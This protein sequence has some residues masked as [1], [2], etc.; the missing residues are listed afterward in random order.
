MC[1]ANISKLTKMHHHFCMVEN[2]TIFGV[3]KNQFF[4]LATTQLRVP[5]VTWQAVKSVISRVVWRRGASKCG[6]RDRRMIGRR[7]ERALAGVSR[8]DTRSMSHVHQLHLKLDTPDMLLIT[9]LA[10]FKSSLASSLRAR[11]LSFREREKARP[12]DG[13]HRMG[14][15]PSNLCDKHTHRGVSYMHV[16]HQQQLPQILR[17]FTQS[18]N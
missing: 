13:S 12:G 1:S 2:K 18:E 9:L 17:V 8:S 7:G 5:A 14:S 15:A 16:H 4:S 6:A 11:T 3:Q 10:L